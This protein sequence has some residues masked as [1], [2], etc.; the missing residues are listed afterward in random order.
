MTSLS[1]VDEGRRQF[2][3]YA[4]A[5]GALAGLTACGGGA[6]RGIEGPREM[7]A[8]RSI[9]EYAGDVSVNNVPA[10]L[11]TFVRPGDVVRTAAQSYVIFVINKDAFVLRSDSEMQIPGGAAPQPGYSLNRGKALGALASRATSIRTPTAFVG[12]RGT[13]IYVESDPG[14]SYV[15]TCYGVTDIAAAANAG[16]VETI[17]AEH[18]DAP[19]YVIDEGGSQRIEPA[20]FKNHDDQE[21]LLIETLVGRSTPYVV[22][23]RL[24]RSRTGYY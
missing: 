11:E 3:L 8:N 23:R 21:L 13:G 24:S 1:D 5:S 17:E 2:L 6:V 15:C 22:P 4:L 19:R 20:P 14:I 16:V 7:P 18:H 10:T 12:I 9:F